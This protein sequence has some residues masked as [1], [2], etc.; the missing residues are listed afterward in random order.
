[1]KFF[2]AKQM[3]R[4]QDG[5][6]YIRIN[7]MNSLLTKSISN[8]HIEEGDRGE[9]C[10]TCGENEYVERTTTENLKS[11]HSVEETEIGGRII[12]SWT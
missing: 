7:F 2:V 11:K 4:E 12:F 9:K 6:N 10:G 1:M 8:D 3:K 5:I